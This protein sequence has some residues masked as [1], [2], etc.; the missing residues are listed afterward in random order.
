MT[1]GGEESGDDC[2]DSS[3]L[4]CGKAKKSVSCK[5]LGKTEKHRIMQ[6]VGSLNPTGVAVMAIAAVVRSLPDCEAHLKEVCSNIVPSS[7]AFYIKHLQEM[8]QTFYN[9]C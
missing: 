7:T 2:Q 6:H 8:Y 9:E 3:S 4:T 1:Q 5:M